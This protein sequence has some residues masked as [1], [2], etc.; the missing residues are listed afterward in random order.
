MQKLKYK[1]V[2][3]NKATVDKKWVVVDAE[4]QNLG[5]L[6]SKVAK[7][8]RGKHKANFTPH[9]DCGDNVILINASKVQLSGQKWTQKTY[10]R[11]T[12]YPGGQRVATAQEVF[13]K[14]PA[15]L[16]ESAV[17]GMLPRNKLGRALLK[18][19]H[20]FV[21]AEHTH[22][23]QKPDDGKGEVNING[24]PLEEYF[25]MKELQYKFNQP[26]QLTETE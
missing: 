5:R 25:P 22:E 11:H 6:C 18:N 17:K 12:G 20:V 13:T 2:S 9:V 8:I 7:I 23:A 21:D 24:K 14:D 16:I 15:R 3:A 4:G 26:F 1:T 10:I 19:L